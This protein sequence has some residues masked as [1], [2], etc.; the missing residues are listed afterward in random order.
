MLKSICQGA[1]MRAFL[2]NPKATRYLGEL[3]EAYRSFVNED[4]RGTRIRDLVSLT[5]GNDGVGDAGPRKTTIDLSKSA[6]SGL[7]TCLN[8]GITSNCPRFVP[9][10]TAKA[11]EQIFTSSRAIKCRKVVISGVSYQPRA[12]S[13]KNSNIYFQPTSQSQPTA[14]Y[15]EN[16]I[17]HARKDPS[18]RMV[19]ETFLIVNRYQDLTPSEAQHDHYRQFP[20]VGGKL[21]HDTILQEPHVIRP[22]SVI[23]HC[24]KTTTHHDDIVGGILHILPLDRVSLL[25]LYRCSPTAYSLQY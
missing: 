11:A 2:S 16:I 19:E 6:Y 14:G 18:G 17:L 25:L 5:A 12:I 9:E 21:Y 23:C 4:Q 13:S 3:I 7:L 10:L 22:S 15:I 1:N 20:L 24:A 8:A